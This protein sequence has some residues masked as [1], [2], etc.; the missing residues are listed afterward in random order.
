MA[1]VALALVNNVEHWRGRQKQRRGYAD[2]VGD[3]GSKRVMLE[4]R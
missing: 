1:T 2:Q 4:D 3:P